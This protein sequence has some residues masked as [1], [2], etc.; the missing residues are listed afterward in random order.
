MSDRDYTVK[1]IHSSPKQEFEAL[2]ETRRREK[3]YDA[4]Y[5]KR[6]CPPSGPGTKETLS[7]FY[8]QLYS[9]H[10]NTAGERNNGSSRLDNFSREMQEDKEKSGH[11]PIALVIFLITLVPVLLLFGGV[12]WAV[13]NTFILK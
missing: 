10:G 5:A 4:E 7:P 1:I 2:D 12:I 13:I 9:I 8:G 3:I 6:C 11:D